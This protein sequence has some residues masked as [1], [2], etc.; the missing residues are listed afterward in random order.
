MVEIALLS[1]RSVVG[2]ANTWSVAII[3]KTAVMMI[4][5]VTIGILMRRATA[6][7]EAP[8]SSAASYSSDGTALSAV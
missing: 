3:E 5:G 1:G 7:C 8:S 2:S 6:T 4:D